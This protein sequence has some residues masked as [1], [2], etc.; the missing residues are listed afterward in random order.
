MYEFGNDM[1]LRSKFTIV[2]V[3]FFCLLI[4]WVSVNIFGI[5]RFGHP[6]IHKENGNFRFK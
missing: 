3:S 2:R 5:F 4:F 6:V 1:T